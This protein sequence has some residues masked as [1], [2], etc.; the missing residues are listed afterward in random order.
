[1]TKVIIKRQLIAKIDHEL[2]LVAN[3][4][5]VNRA[6]IRYAEGMAAALRNLKNDIEQMD[7]YEVYIN[8]TEDTKHG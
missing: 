2:R 6:M 7:T 3:A 4:A 8:N 1:M 5:P